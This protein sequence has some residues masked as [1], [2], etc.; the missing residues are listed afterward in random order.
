EDLHVADRQATHVQ[1]PLGAG[2]GAVDERVVA[3]RR[4]PGA[5]A[6]EIGLGPV[7]VLEEALGLALLA[8]GGAAARHVDATAGARPDDAD[9]LLLPW[10]RCRVADQGDERETE[11]EEQR[12][13]TGEVAHAHR[14]AQSN[15]R[16]RR[17]SARR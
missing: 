10:R 7:A 4:R 17:R 8:D 11:G 5:A 6:L 3:G 1:R 9:R 2:E 16:A 14:S 13:G 12:T 15:I